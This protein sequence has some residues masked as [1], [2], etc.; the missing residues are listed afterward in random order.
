[1]NFRKIYES[2]HPHLTEMAMKSEHGIVGAYEGLE[3]FIRSQLK[4]KSRDVSAPA[5]EA[6]CL[7]NVGKTFPSGNKVNKEETLKD[8][9]KD[10]P[11]LR[12]FYNKTLLKV[13]SSIKLKDGTS[14]MDAKNEEGIPLLDIPGDLKDY[15]KFSLSSGKSSGGGGG[16]K[17]KG[18][19]LLNKVLPFI[20]EDKRGAA[21]AFFDS[22]MEEYSLSVIKPIAEKHG[23][24]VSTVLE[25]NEDW[26]EE[27]ANM[28]KERMGKIAALKI[29]KRK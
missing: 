17:A 24:S 28:I 27:V 20:Q 26:P 15:A 4:K 5:Y 18:N 9:T 16:S 10:T 3:L 25:I 1:M 11:N 13:L 7:A 22:V 19:T 12:S 23:V 2:T 29:P 21:S 14:I 8:I 6:W